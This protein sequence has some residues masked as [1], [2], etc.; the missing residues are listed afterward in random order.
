MCLKLVS[1]E[2]SIWGMK[3]LFFACYQLSPFS[4][5]LSLSH[6]LINNGLFVGEDLWIQK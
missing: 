5:S 3:M 1:L 6:I 2:R 4:L